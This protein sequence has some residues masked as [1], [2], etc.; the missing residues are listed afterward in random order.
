[1]AYFGVNTG[2]PSTHFECAPTAGHQTKTTE[3]NS[4]VTRRVKLINQS[5]HALEINKITF[6]CKKISLVKPNFLRK[7]LFTQQ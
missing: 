2:I 1:M 4:H 3:T 5:Y 7:S 6:V